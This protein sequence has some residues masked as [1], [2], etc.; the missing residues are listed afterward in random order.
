MLI[1]RPD[2]TPLQRAWL[3]LAVAFLRRLKPRD[4]QS[5]RIFG[6]QDNPAEVKGHGPPPGQGPPGDGRHATQGRPPFAGVTSIVQMIHAPGAARES[7]TTRQGPPGDGT[8]TTGTNNG[9]PGSGIHTTTGTNHQGPPGTGNHPP[10]T[11]VSGSPIAAGSLVA[12]AAHALI[13]GGVVGSIGGGPPG[14]GMTM[15]GGSTN[16]NFTDE[17]NNGIV[18]RYWTQARGTWTEDSGLETPAGSGQRVLVYNASTEADGMASMTLTAESGVPAVFMRGALDG[19]SQVAQGYAV[20]FSAGTFQ[21]FAIVDGTTTLDT[22]LFDSGVGKV[23]GDVWGVDC[24]GTSISI[25]RNGVKLGT[26]VD[27]SWAGAGLI[28]LTCNGSNYNFD[29]FSIAP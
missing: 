19:S 1:E 8:H 26:V 13:G 24:R 20:R 28:G 12:A 3:E 14:A 18:D 25:Y 23:A 4:L 6:G 11:L 7:T 2:A 15:T 22:S 21:L 9:P 16:N 5:R 17:F 10:V 29:A 27:A